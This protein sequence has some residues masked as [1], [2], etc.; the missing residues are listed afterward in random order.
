MKKAIAALFIALGAILVS[1]PLRGDIGVPK[2]DVE[3]I[4]L[5]DASCSL[6]THM[7]LNPCT[8][9]P[10]LYV[11]FPQGKNVA[12]FEGYIV[13]MRGTVEFTTCTLPLLHAT[14]VARPKLLLPCPPP[15]CNPGDPP[16]CP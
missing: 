13:S 4:L 11:V 1:N 2:V 8:K 6:A 12:R 7:L 10:S 3:G 15:V 16:P 14:T 5:R 9:A